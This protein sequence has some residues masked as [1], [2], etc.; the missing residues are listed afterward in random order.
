MARLKPQEQFP[1]EPLFDLGDDALDPVKR[2]GPAFLPSSARPCSTNSRNRWVR[3]STNSCRSRGERGLDIE[4]LRDSMLPD[5][6]T[7]PA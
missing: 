1:P 7:A 6:F 4:F 5:T 2:H 3:A